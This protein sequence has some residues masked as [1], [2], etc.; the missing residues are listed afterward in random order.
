[1]ITLQ[2]T[3]T[4]PKLLAYVTYTDPRGKGAPTLIRNNIAAAQHLSP[5]RG[6]EHVLLE[7]HSKIRGNK[8]RIS[9]LNVYGRLAKKD[10]KLDKI[11]EDSLDTS[12]GKQIVIVGYFNAPHSI[13]GCKFN[14]RRC[15]TL[16][17]MI[18]QEVLA[19]LNKPNTPTSLGRR[20]SG[21]TTPDLTMAQ[22]ILATKCQ[23]LG[24]SLGSD[25]EIMSIQIRGPRFK[26]QTGTAQLKQKTGQNQAPMQSALNTKPK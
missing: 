12:Q 4:K 20:T 13:W 21:Y 9:I 10:L 26:T 22:G 19:L 16:V 23:N 1:M 7:I 2:E 14:S 8:T 5:Q 15:K 18:E 25:H 24:T 6:G 11:I 3:S 17:S